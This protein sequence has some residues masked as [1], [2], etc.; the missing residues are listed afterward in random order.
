[1]F[2]SFGLAGDLLFKPQISGIGGEIYSTIS[3]FAAEQ[4]KM[5]RMY[6]MSSGTSMA[7]PYVAGYA[8]VC[9]LKEGFIITL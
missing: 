8:S 2:T 1:M 4:Q 7:C 9:L 6:A 3:P 5:T